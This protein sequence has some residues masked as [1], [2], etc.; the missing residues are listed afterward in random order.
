MKLPVDT[1]SNEEEALARIAANHLRQLQPMQSGI[2][3]K[4]RDVEIAHIVNI[5]KPPAPVEEAK[6]AFFQKH[7]AAV[8]SHPVA[9]SSVETAAA[10]HKPV[11]HMSTSPLLDTESELGAAVTKLS[12]ELVIKSARC[13]TCV[14]VVCFTVCSGTRKAASPSS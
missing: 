4:L 12:E 10:A 9:Q 8:P 6:P 14:S 3:P 2:A 11:P 7:A 5:F 13:H 1:R